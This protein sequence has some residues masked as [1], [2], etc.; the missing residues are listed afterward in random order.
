MVLW[1]LEINLYFGW[2][3]KPS[4]IPELACWGLYFLLWSM[5]ADK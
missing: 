3:H 5:A 2:F 1:G 4:S